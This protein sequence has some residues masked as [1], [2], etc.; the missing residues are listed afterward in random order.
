MLYIYKNRDIKKLTPIHYKWISD[1]IYC[2]NND[3]FMD[4]S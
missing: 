4:E 1:K 2:T 3:N